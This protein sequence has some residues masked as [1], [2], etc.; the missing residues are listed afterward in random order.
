[1]CGK[2]EALNFRKTNVN[3]RAFKI[4]KSF[5]CINLNYVDIILSFSLTLNLCFSL[6]ERTSNM[7]AVICMAYLKCSLSS[8]CLA[9]RFHEWFLCASSVWPF[10]QSCYC[11]LLFAT[12][13]CYNVWESIH[14]TNCSLSP[15]I[16]C[17]KL[18]I[19]IT[20]INRQLWHDVSLHQRN[21]NINIHIITY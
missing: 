10:Q 19:L 13:L 11:I 8:L 1:M 18:E 20:F 14:N 3:K 2:K 7:C 16:G 4:C 17:I 15:V 21:L 9:W 6:S 12:H 5:L